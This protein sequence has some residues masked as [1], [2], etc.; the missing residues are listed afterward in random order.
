[1]RPG[2]LV[3]H[4]GRDA[5]KRSPQH[6]YPN[7][8]DEHT[9]SPR[10]SLQTKHN[11]LKTHTIGSLP[12]LSH[13]LNFPSSDQ[14]N[15]YEEEE[16]EYEF[17]D[18]S[19]SDDSDDNTKSRSTDLSNSSVASSSIAR[20]S[21]ITPL[22]TSPDTPNIHTNTPDSSTNTQ[23]YFRKQN[24]S[25]HLAAA[26]G[27][28]FLNATL[29]PPR[30]YII[31]TQPLSAR[32]PPRY[33]QKSAESDNGSDSPPTPIMK[34]KS[35]VRPDAPRTLS[36]QNL[37]DIL[38]LDTDKRT[39]S[40]VG[41]KSKKSKKFSQIYNTIRK[42]RESSGSPSVENL[43]NSVTIHSPNFE[44]KK[45]KKEKGK[46]SWVEGLEL[47]KEGKLQMKNKRH[48]YKSYRFYLDSGNLYK[49]KRNKF[50]WTLSLFL[51]QVKP[52]LPKKSKSKTGSE[53]HYTFGFELITPNGSFC[54]LAKD[55]ADRNEWMDCIQNVCNSLTLQSLNSPIPLYKPSEDEIQE[56]ESNARLR[57][58]LK[59]VLEMEGNNL[60]ADCNSPNPEW[61]SINIGVFVCIQC[62]G[63]HRSL[64]THVSKIRSTELDLW[65]SEQILFMES[66]GNTESNKC[67]EY[68]VPQDWPKPTES[69]DDFWRETWIR[70][71]YETKLFTKEY[72][73]SSP[74]RPPPPLPVSIS[75]PTNYGGNISPRASTTKRL[76]I[77]QSVADPRA[78]G[79]RPSS[80][81]HNPYNSIDNTQLKQAI[82][83]LLRTDPMFRNEVRSLLQTP[84][85]LYTPHP[86][87]DSEKQTTNHNTHH[88]KVL[89]SSQL[90]P[91]S[92]SLTKTPLPSPPLNSQNP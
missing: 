92:L 51:A 45:E 3:N 42:P 36:S 15:L 89:Y 35:F 23:K 73:L 52:G 31:Q 9:P 27:G 57:V 17:E 56:E 40:D 68:S 71:K 81:S 44:D 4:N 18:E 65:D 72:C 20:S 24:S 82:L 48:R 7:E 60:C 28:S 76:S 62:S 46:P 78:Y 34:S 63:V 58:D 41:K 69:S 70:A 38:N 2:I 32:I 29:S 61:G 87:S 6:P 47:V 22:S 10:P 11:Q 75:P 74:T 54:F 55:E 83:T 91:P 59:R 77:S 66:N 1:M 33:T 80:P 39:K 67:W 12:P 19:S 8:I 5:L 50:P 16:E 13:S 86:P 84:T 43:Y 30:P 21:A 53:V 14:H 26:P 49:E 64:G 25:P 88:N 85:E 79:S 90:Q 37:T